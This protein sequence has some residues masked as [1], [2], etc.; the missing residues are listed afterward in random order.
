MRNISEYNATDRF[1][2]L[3]YQTKD[4]Y[5]YNYRGA[6]G[7]SSRLRDFRIT[8]VISLFIPYEE[9]KFKETDLFYKIVRDKLKNCLY[10]F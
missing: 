6:K 5:S 8:F 3:F 2:S 7:G 9:K 10:S 4:N 1:A